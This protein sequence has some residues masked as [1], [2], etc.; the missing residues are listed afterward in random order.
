MTSSSLCTVGYINCVLGNLIFS[1]SQNMNMKRRMLKKDENHGT[2]EKNLSIKFIPAH[3]CMK[4]DSLMSTNE[5][6]ALKA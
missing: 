4:N 6:E 1:A 5:N 3:P 2:N